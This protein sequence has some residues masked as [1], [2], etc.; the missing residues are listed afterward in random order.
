MNTDE[1]TIKWGPWRRKEPGYVYYP[2]R[3]EPQPDGRLELGPNDAPPLVRDPH[4]CPGVVAKAVPPS[5][6]GHLLVTTRRLL[7]T[8]QGGCGKTYVLAKAMA[9]A[10]G[11]L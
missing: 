3:G 4:N 9:G 11:D 8:G 7:I 6:T 5:F 2:M 1:R 10:H